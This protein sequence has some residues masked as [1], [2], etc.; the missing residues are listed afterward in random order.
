MAPTGNFNV[1]FDLIARRNEVAKE[2]NLSR[3]RPTAKHEIAKFWKRRCYALNIFLLEKD[4][5]LSTYK[6]NELSA[7]IYTEPIV[8]QLIFGRIGDQLVTISNLEKARGLKPMFR[9]TDECYKEWLEF[10]RLQT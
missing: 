6:R 3:M 7:P 8:K 1:Y 9:I 5:H 2:W 10:S 4:H